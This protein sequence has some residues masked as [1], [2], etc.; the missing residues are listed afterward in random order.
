VVIPV[1]WRRASAAPRRVLSLDV[2]T[3]GL[4]RRRDRILAVG[5]V[6]L[7][8]DAVRWGDRYYA[9]VANP[10]PGRPLAAAEIEALR[11]HQILP[12]ELVGAEPLAAVLAE[13][14]RRCAEADA[15]L[16][17]GAAVDVGFLRRAFRDAGRAWS[18]PPVL[19]TLRLLGKLRRRERWLGDRDDGPP[20]TLA[21]ARMHFGLPP[22][23]PH[24]ALY[25]AVGAAELYLVL[26]DRLAG[27]ARHRRPAH[28]PQRRTAAKE[29]LP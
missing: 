16:C 5:T 18:P 21:A 29:A 10:R 7:V 20:H 14:E 24:H 12:G 23:P 27:D 1:P 17:H 28:R 8:D 3:T 6:P 4:D 26:R 13:V 25:D 15:L 9:L 11:A 2:E 19:D 22:Y